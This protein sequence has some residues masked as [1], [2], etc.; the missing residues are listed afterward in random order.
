MKKRYILSAALLALFIT[1]NFVTKQDDA[2]DK[3]KYSN[4][5]YSQR[6][7]YVKGAIK[8]DSPNEF[9]NYFKLIKSE[10]GN[11][12]STY[13]PNYLFTE[14]EKVRKTTKYSK[15]LNDSWISR[16]PGNV[17]GRARGIIIDPD[18][19]TANTWFIAAVGGG[20]WKTSDAGNN[21]TELT[22]DKGSLS[23]SYM[24][25]APSNHDVI[26]LGTG[27]GF[28]NLDAL[29]GQGLWKS[30]DRGVTWNQI[31]ITATSDFG[32][33]N[34]VIVNPTDENILLIAT[35]TGIFKSIDGGVNWT[36]DLANT[37]KRVQQIVHSPSDFNLMLATVNG[38][39]IIKSSDAGENWNTVSV[40]DNGRIE[41]AYA[42]SNDDIIYAS[43]QGADSDAPSLIYVSRD[44][45]D[46][47]SECTGG[48]DFLGG[49]GWYDNTIVVDPYDENTFFVAGVHI[50]KVICDSNGNSLDVTML[51]NNY[52]SDPALHKGTHV[53]NH[54]FTTMK[55][56]DATDKFRLVGTNDG[57]MC[58]TDNEG[59]TFVQPNAG[60]VTTQFYGVDKANGKD[61]YIGGM[62]DNSCYLSPLGSTSVGD[63]QFVFGG[64]GFDVVWNY[65]DENKVMLT[66]Q[67]NN[68]AVTHKGINSIIED[69]VED[70]W[71]ADVSTGSDLAP[72]VTQLAQSKQFTD[73]VITYSKNEIW[74]TEDFGI[75]WKKVSMP[76]EFGYDA[77]N[78]FF[79]PTIVRVSLSDP[80]IVWAGS[81]VHPN[82]P[83]Y[84]S[85]DFG[86]KFKAVKSSS[87]VGSYISGFATH[88]T[89]K[90]TAYALFSGSGNA[91]ILKT[92]DL[93]Q[94][95][96]D[97]SGFNNGVSQNGFPNVA[98]FDMLVVP[99]SEG[100]IWVGTE[101]GIFETIDEGNSWHLLQNGLPP[102]SV[103]DLVVVND[104]VVIGTHGRGVW[105]VK[106]PELQGYVPPEVLIP[107][108]VDANYLFEGLEQKT[109]IKVSYKSEY[110]NVKVYLNDE[111]IE[112][113][114]ET[115]SKGGEL[116]L[117][118]NIIEGYNTIK[119]IVVKS[120]V[121]LETKVK[122]KGLKLKTE[123]SQF[124][125]D[126]NDMSLTSEEFD[127][128]S[129]YINQP[130]GF[131]NKGLTTAHPYP[132]NRDMPIYLRTPIVVN[133]DKPTFT[134]KDVAI[135]EIGTSGTSY[136]NPD[137]FD[138]VTVEGSKDGKEWVQMITPY[139]AGF[140]S[141][142]KTKYKNSENGDKNDF[143]S[144][145]FKTTDFFDP[146][147][148]IIVRFRLFSDPL[149]AGWGWIID[150]L[151][152]QK[153]A[154]SL[155]DNYLS[156]TFK[157]YPNPV[158]DE[159]LYLESTTDSRIMNVKMFNISGQLLLDNNFSNVE[160]TILDISS[161]T[162]GQYILKV[163]TDK[164]AFTK[165]IMV[166]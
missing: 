95:W 164:G 24:A 74:R 58:F 139:D 113:I 110:D 20:V 86:K 68:I 120:G 28:G 83:M 78:G 36:D 137:F 114:T 34:R 11:Q 49:Q 43:S 80:S 3:V 147:D 8:K 162:K 136:P 30:I 16:G 138:Y 26:Y 6:K 52:G 163:E 156:T 15:K 55:L 38:L 53:D 153:D 56:D 105:S 133:K 41:M 57:G 17:G 124:V 106:L 25:M 100:K 27:E 107:A 4:K 154:L 7:S 75:A 98:V 116:S 88:P 115:V 1:F 47:W 70:Y 155:E 146:G 29:G 148:I 64:D 102:V 32:M 127:G 31:E 93:G 23:A 48:E 77:V 9:A 158:A 131:D 10:I 103:Y 69:K 72:F 90:N 140:N 21:W 166:K 66:S 46:H 141:V 94:T 5:V 84:V 135:V 118:N 89:D 33:I 149:T 54:Y 40:N 85:T 19:A 63:W 87:L 61:L 65:D 81:S 108:S 150:D 97:I 121:S 51:T 152:I 130:S 129:F 142:W 161:F 145:S 119:V 18:D 13:D 71:T 132:E 117:V 122:V 92:T 165:K 123:S 128:G 79:R 2:G 22:V 144:H 82:V 59:D 151:Q 99:N 104:Q 101:L 126:F 12:S 134:Y 44:K 143:V 112:E 111:L 14:L 42:P 157:V 73:L 109:E 159:T 35:T 60:F 96:N 37:D 62:Q 125:T 160:K 67:F 45:G 91:K 76:K 50:F 39:G